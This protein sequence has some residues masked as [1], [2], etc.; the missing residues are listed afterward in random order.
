[1]SGPAV[2]S[3]AARAL[4]QL[5]E[6]DGVLVLALGGPMNGRFGLALRRVPEQNRRQIAAALR[7]LAKEVEASLR[8]VAARV[9][10]N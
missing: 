4:R 3:A 8:A 2:D 6:V 1:M 5:G 10:G 7:L 9:E